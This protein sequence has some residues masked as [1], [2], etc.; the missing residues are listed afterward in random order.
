MGMGY[1]A[2]LLPM[3]PSLLMWQEAYIESW[4]SQLRL[5]LRRG[6]E[7]GITSTTFHACGTSPGVDSSCKQ[8]GPGI[9]L[10]VNTQYTRSGSAGVTHTSFYS[11]DSALT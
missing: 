5:S 2:L 3:Q 6:G 1:K 8:W 11:Y 4:P 10:C 9:N 7:T